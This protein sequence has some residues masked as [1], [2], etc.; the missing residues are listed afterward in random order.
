MFQPGSVLLGQFGVTACHSE[1]AERPR[2]LVSSVNGTG[3][4]AAL[5][6]TAIG[7]ASAA[8]HDGFRSG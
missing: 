2:N 6:M 5:G 7:A 1:G 4:R 3:F 8:E